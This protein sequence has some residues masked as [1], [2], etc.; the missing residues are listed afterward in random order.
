MAYQ[1]ETS[2]SINGIG[3][4]L[5]MVVVVKGMMI[6]GGQLLLKDGICFFAFLTVCFFTFSKISSY[7]RVYRFYCLVASSTNKEM[8]KPQASLC[9]VTMLLIIVRNFHTVFLDLVDES[10]SVCFWE[11]LLS[12]SRSPPTSR[13]SS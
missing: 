12:N 13:R 11:V 8:Y 4:K 1:K 9:F 5:K 2:S 6:M 10:G 3:E 7:L